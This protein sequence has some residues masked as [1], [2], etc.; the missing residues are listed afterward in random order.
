MQRRSK[1]KVR[2]R[3]RGKNT[4]R[5]RPKRPKVVAYFA[6]ARK[7]GVAGMCDPKMVATLMGRANCAELSRSG[8]VFTKRGCLK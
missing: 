6:V 7:N 5:S 4:A 1:L 2:G 3:D 8:D